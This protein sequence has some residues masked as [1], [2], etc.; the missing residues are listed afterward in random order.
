[1]LSKPVANGQ[2][3]HASDLDTHAQPI[4]RPHRTTP[5][6]KFPLQRMPCRNLIYKITLVFQVTHTMQASKPASQPA[7]RSPLRPFH[8]KCTPHRHPC[9][10]HSDGIETFPTTFSLSLSLHHLIQTQKN[11][12]VPPI[13]RT[14]N[15]IQTITKHDRRHFNPGVATSTRVSINMTPSEANHSQF[16]TPWATN[17]TLTTILAS[18]H[19]PSFRPPHSLR[20]GLI[21]PAFINAAHV[22]PSSYTISTLAILNTTNTASFRLFYFFVAIKNYSMA[23]KPTHTHTKKTLSIISPSSKRLQSIIQSIS[24]TNLECARGCRSE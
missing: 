10:S 22:S 20:G 1:M 13:P 14:I 9:I 17:H 4:P 24:A 19:N 6:A 23:W 8:Q 5:K 11:W 15:S 7:L 21:P 3:I 16:R 2:P 18:S 12:W